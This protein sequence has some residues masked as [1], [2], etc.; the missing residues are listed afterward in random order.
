VENDFFGLL[1]DKSMLIFCPLFSLFG[2]IFPS[3][4][5]VTAESEKLLPKLPPGQNESQPD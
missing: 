1:P 2:F 5:F 4:C 3:C